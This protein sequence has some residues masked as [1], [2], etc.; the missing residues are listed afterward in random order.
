MT[1]LM[2]V[3]SDGIT[4]QYH[5]VANIDQSAA[6]LQ[7]SLAAFVGRCNQV[8]IYY[9]ERP[10]E[11]K[12]EKLVEE[13]E[14]SSPESTTP[15]VRSAQSAK[16]IERKHGKLWEALAAFLD[17]RN[18]PHT[19]A[20]VGRWGPDLR[21]KKSPLALFQIKV[22]GKASDI[23]RGLGQL[24]LYEKMMKKPYDKIL[25]L[26]DRPSD[27]VAQYLAEFG[28]RVVCFRQSRNKITLPPGLLKGA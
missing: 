19:N 12:I 3:F 4:R 15:Y 7:D 22:E 8:R 17:A 28:V 16:I 6:A 18:I 10:E 24:M 26:P 11:A 25:L 23:Q 1:E 20:R 27:K 14:V 2:F 13:A 5:P 21:T 9:T